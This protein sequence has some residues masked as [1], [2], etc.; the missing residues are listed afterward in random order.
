MPRK[1]SQK[2]ASIHVGED[3]GGYFGNFLIGIHLAAADRSQAERGAGNGAL[4]RTPGRAV[5]VLAAQF[6][7]FGPVT[8]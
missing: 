8:I 3:G 7:V 4:V 5:G 1:F 6:A 2:Q